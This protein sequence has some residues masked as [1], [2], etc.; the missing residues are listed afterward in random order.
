MVQNENNQTGT[1]H[2]V[3][4]IL[5]NYFIALQDSQGVCT[6]QKT[7]LIKGTAVIATLLKGGKTNQII[8]MRNL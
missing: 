1:W 2:L 3:H 7:R 6:S 4:K 5:L 8:H